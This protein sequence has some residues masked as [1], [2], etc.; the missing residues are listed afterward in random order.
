M[1]TSISQHFIHHTLFQRFEKDWELM[2][3][4]FDPEHVPIV[5]PRDPE[6]NYEYDAHTLA[7]GTY[8]CTLPDW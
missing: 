5:K 3:V 1:P 8:C 6:D 7:L 2:G 4:T